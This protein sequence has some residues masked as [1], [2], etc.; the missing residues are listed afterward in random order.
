MDGLS[1]I[2]G[3]SMLVFLL[4]YLSFNLANK[5]KIFIVIKTFLIVFGLIL[6]SYIPATIIHL[7]RDCGILN[8]GS[9]VCYLSNGTQVANY[10]VATTQVG[11]GLSVVYVTFLYIVLSGLFLVIFWFGIISIIKWWRTRKLLK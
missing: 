9:Y 4:F 10:G 11:S 2:T 3:I 7:D 8:N 1:I 6:L 5:P